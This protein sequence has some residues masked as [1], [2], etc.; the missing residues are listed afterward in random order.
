MNRP[1]VPVYRSAPKR[2]RSRWPLTVLVTV[3]LIAVAAAASFQFGLFDG[4]APAAKPQP[5]ATQ[6]PSPI[7]PVETPEPEPEIHRPTLQQ[8]ATEPEII[9][10]P[11]AAAS[12]L[13][14]SAAIFATAPLA[15]VAAPAEIARVERLAVELGAPLLIVDDEAAD[16]VAAEIE[17]LEALTVLWFGPEA[18]ALPGVDV[19]TGP[20]AAS[21]A[22]PKPVTL[23]DLPNLPLTEPAQP[24]PGAL[25]IL[26]AAPTAAVSVTAQAAGYEVIEIPD[27]DLLAAAPDL[28]DGPVLVLDA[29]QSPPE[30]LQWQL[31]ALARGAQLPGGGYRIFP[32]KRYVALYGSPGVSALGVLG[33]QD[34]ESSIDRAREHAELYEPL[35]D[36]AVIPT[37]EIIATVASA[38][39]GPG[40]N[41]TN[42]VPVEQLL[43][44]VEAAQEAGVYV[45]LDLQPGRKDFLTQAKLYEELLRYPNVGLAL[46]P[47]WRLKPNQVHL[48]QIGSVEIDEVNAVSAWL[49]D[50]VREHDLPQKMLVLHQF[51]L[52]MIKDRDKLDTSAPEIAVVIHADG[53]GTQPEKQATWRVLHRDAPANIWWGW[54]NFYVKDSP[55]LT[56]ELTYQV[57]PLP[58][59]VTYQ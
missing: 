12:A 22:E 58:E 38:S 33:H 59:L 43:P 40:N 3:L 49:A 34:L 46:D 32:D 15:V 4:P 29:N 52:S 11:A 30:S 7:E 45:L 35:T 47:E 20:I 25:V 6:S 5:T 17:R 9:A 18:P 14:V 51:R 44:W 28:P 24:A 23:A 42:E 55:M 37:F 19:I 10:E 27:G 39:P 57:E 13:A 16:A 2:A 41:Y 56:P 36:D 48:R 50:L 21:T 8:A 31:R 54:K 26:G 1:T 53:Q